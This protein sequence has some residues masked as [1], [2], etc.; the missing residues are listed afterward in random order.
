LRGVLLTVR[1][2]DTDLAEQ[3]FHTEGTGFVSQDRDDALAD[4]LYPNYQLVLPQ[5][6][7]K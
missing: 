6:T 2:V 5:M 1:A 4:R 7:K 3:A